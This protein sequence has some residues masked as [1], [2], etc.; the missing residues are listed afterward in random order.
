MV[1]SAGSADQHHLT[2]QYWYPNAIQPASKCDRRPGVV[3]ILFSS[4]THCARRPV[5]KYGRRHWYCHSPVMVC[6]ISK[7]CYTVPSHI[8]KQ[9]HVPAPMGGARHP[10]LNLDHPPLSYCT[11]VQAADS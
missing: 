11:I 8:A 10:F 1:L 4:M 3:K 7:G 9:Y 6:K 5:T 2:S